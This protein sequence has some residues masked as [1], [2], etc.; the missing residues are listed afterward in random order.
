M[1]KLFHTLNDLRARRCP[2]LL[3]AGFFDGVHRGHQKVMRRAMAAARQ[4]LGETWVLTFDPHPRKVLTPRSAPALLTSTPHK[5]RLLQSWGAI[6]CVVIP[7]TP[8]YARQEPEAFI[9]ALTRSIP[10]LS[11]IF[12]GQNWTFGRHGHGHATL[13]KKLAGNYGFK[14]VIIPPV[15]WRGKPVSSTRIRSAVTAGRLSDA[16]RMLG[17]PFSVLGTVIPGRQIG[18]TL[19][20]PTANLDSHN[21]VHPPNGVYAVTAVISGK[22][23]PGIANLG[24]R[25]TFRQHG[26]DTPILELHILDR[27]RNLYGK[28][29]EVFFLKRLRAERKFAS[30]AALQTQI[31]RDITKVRRWFQGRKAGKNKG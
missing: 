18:Q 29:I 22:H 5:L 31:I 4:G 8:A 11:H 13:L 3:A 12:I 9:A 15:C 25:P 7:F 23:Y 10:A 30:L 21:E 26:Q 27:H 24:T 1:K 28:T 14:V 20:I 2:V 6:G 16:A 17:R 19:G